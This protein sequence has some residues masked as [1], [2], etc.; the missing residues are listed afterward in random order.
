GKGGKQ[1]AQ[2]K[3]CQG[4]AGR[5]IPARGSDEDGNQTKV[6]SHRLVSNKGLSKHNS[7]T[8]G[9]ANEKPGDRH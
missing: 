5:E 2:D 3:I 1:I 7:P 8:G 9:K 6:A 4:G